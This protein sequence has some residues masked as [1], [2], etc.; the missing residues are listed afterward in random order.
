MRSLAPSCPYKRDIR[1]GAWESGFHQTVGPGLRTQGKGTVRGVCAARMRDGAQGC[2]ENRPPS[3]P[4]VS[5]RMSV[6]KMFV[7]IG[8]ER[9]LSDVGLHMRIY[10]SIH[11]CLLI[12]ICI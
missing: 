2:Q 6:T 4:V 7:N 9:E 8:C 10:T 5:D 11:I 3:Q 12:C 1:N